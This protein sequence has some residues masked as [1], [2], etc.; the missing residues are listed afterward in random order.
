MSIDFFG[1]DKPKPSFFTT[2]TN[3]T[4]DAATV[5]AEKYDY[6]LGEKSPGATALNQQILT[7]G[8]DALRSGLAATKDAEIKSTQLAVLGDLVKG[9]VTNDAVELADSLTFG[10]NSS[11]G[12]VVEKAY[13]DKLTSDLFF[14]PKR[15][16]DLAIIDMSFGVDPEKTNILLDIARDNIA[17]AEVVQKEMEDLGIRKEAMGPYNRFGEIIE[18][19]IPF[20]S[21]YNISDD[22]QLMGS[23]LKDQARELMALPIDERQRVLHDRVKEIAAVNINDAITYLNAM[24]AYG[25]SDEFWGNAQSF[26]DIGDVLPIGLAFKTVRKTTSALAKTSKVPLAEVLASTGKTQEA[27]AARIVDIAN[28]ERLFFESVDEM[29]AL[30]PT[31]GMKDLIYELP[32]FANPFGFLFGES[33]RHGAREFADRIAPTVL[34]IARKTVRGIG[35]RTTIARLGEAAIAQA[36]EI[37]TKQARKEFTHVNDAIMDIQHLPSELSPVSNID[38]VRVAFGKTSAEVFDDFEQ[39]EYFAKMEYKLKDY[40]IENLGEGWQIAVYRDIDETPGSVRDLIIETGNTTPMSFVNSLLGGLRS[41][42]DILPTDVVDANKVMVHGIQ[43]VFHTLRDI[44]KPIIDLP[45]ASRDKFQRFTSDMRDF[46]RHEGTKHTTGRQF[47]TLAEFEEQWVNDFGELPT[48]AEATAYYSYIRLGEYDYILRNL[49]I[50]GSKARQGIREFTITVP[51]PE[52]RPEGVAARMSDITRSS[53]VSSPKFEGRMVTEIPEHKDAGVLIWSPSTG[54]TEYVLWSEVD[55]DIRKS[56]TEMVDGNAGIIQIASPYNLPLKESTGVSQIVNF[57][58]TDAYQSNRLSFKQIP[59]N[60]GG[61]KGYDYGNYVKQPKTMWINKGQIY[62]GDVTIRPANSSGDAAEYAT[63]LDKARQLLK[64][65][66]P[67]KTRVGSYGGREIAAE[68]DDDVLNIFREETGDLY[69]QPEEIIFRESVDPIDGRDFDSYVRANL[70]ESPEELRARFASGELSID[71]PIVVV[72]KGRSSLELDSVKSSLG[73]VTNANLDPLNLFRDVDK[74]FAGERNLDLN[75]IVSGTEENPL[76]QLHSPRLIDPLEIANRAA[77]NLSRNT[78]LNDYKVKVANHFVEEFGDKDI[79]TIPKELLRNNPVAFLSDPSKI[80]NKNAPDQRLL[81]AARNFQRAYA[82]LMGI[83]SPMSRWW[84]AEKAKLEDA[85][86]D[87]LSQGKAKWIADNALAQHR[88]PVTFARKVAFDLKLGLFNPVQLFKQAQTLV[89]ITALTNPKIASQASSVYWH[90]RMLGRSNQSKEMRNWWASKAKVFGW[91]KDDFLEAYDHLSRSGLLRVEGEHAWADDMLDPRIYTTTI[92]KTLDKG[93]MFFREGERIT[94][95]AGFNAAYLEW[96]AANKGKVFD[97]RAFQ[98][99]MRRQDDLTVNMTRASNAHWQQAGGGILSIPTQ[100]FSY[101]IRLW[102]QM[103]GGR[104]SW[105]QKGKAILTYSLLYGFP[106]GVG[107]T[108]GGIYPWYEDLKQSALEHGVKP[109]D[110]FEE[111]FHKGILGMLTQLVTGEEYD[112]GASWGPTGLPWIKDILDRDATVQ[113]FILGASGG[114]FEEIIASTAPLMSSIGGIFSDGGAPVVGRDFIDFARNISTVNNAAKLYYAMNAMRY[115]SKTG[116]N[117]S[118]EWSGWDGFLSGVM[119]IQ[120]TELN[121]IGRFMDSAKDRQKHVDFA[122]KQMIKYIQ[123]GLDS[124][125]PETRNSYFHMAKQWRVLGDI[126]PLDMT[127]IYKQA[128]QGK[129]KS[130]IDS[131]NWNFFIDNAPPSQAKERRKYYMEN[132]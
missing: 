30:D 58:V 102:E 101:Q 27:A 7:G 50:Y 18:N 11:P 33:F 96:K 103:I 127:R 86:Y 39:A 115:E 17:W 109:A 75:S 41:S 55:E 56:V 93:R 100:F 3:I 114:T 12:T 31:G 62:T 99:V 63:R 105:T 67:S 46:V 92:G 74:E 29:A 131:L 61:H 51:N 122:E 107:G 97:R 106:I 24:Y 16:D 71:N 35:N 118:M 73:P 15:T 85:L 95:I 8:E 32:S 38:S 120:P 13:A 40:Q 14:T 121:N 9:P 111:L 6:A 28:K 98:T 80:W 57:V 66:T 26:M 64:A 43:E 44:A 2:T 5:R 52:S 81:A 104:L 130:L 53:S 54:K 49:A 87:N 110:G 117:I 23:N 20:T 91:S 77:A 88:D 65:E 126:S 119:G 84:T 69:L 42:T 10:V 37:A 108:I 125:D 4:S 89:H 60:P 128:A 59:F 45:R 129:Y 112:V 22:A 124:D 116:T 36:V 47:N 34:D 90:M 25:D 72:R 123:R 83:Q 1:E 19:Y 48:E 78:Y 68:S 132:N 113:D 79:F 82:D 70:P 21:W 94:R 76:F